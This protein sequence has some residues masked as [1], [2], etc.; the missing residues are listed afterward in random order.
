MSPRIL[1][2]DAHSRHGIAGQGLL[3]ASR[4]QQHES[5]FAGP[6]P[7]RALVLAAR[8]AEA[9]GSLRNEGSNA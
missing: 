4:N 3:R 5:M 1:R 8:K 6:E 7:A 2:L 9:E